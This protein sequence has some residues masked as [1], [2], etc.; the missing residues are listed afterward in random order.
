[1]YRITLAVALAA[2]G[3]SRVAHVPPPSAEGGPTEAMPAPIHDALDEC[4]QHTLAVLNGYRAKANL[5]PLALD[6]SLSAFAQRGSTR[7]ARDRVPHAHMTEHGRATFRGRYRH[8][9]Q[10]PAEGAPIDP[11]NLV[12]SCKERVEALIGQL[13]EQGTGAGHHDAVLDPR[14]TTLGVGLHVEG[15]LVW[16]TN[17]FLE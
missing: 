15:D 11:Q 1:M 6:A 12:A 10:G 2:C 16:I 3:G 4:R 14:H 13:M 8:E 7:Y 9:N 5:A 17:D